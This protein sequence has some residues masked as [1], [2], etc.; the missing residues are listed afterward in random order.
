MVISL[1]IP[2]I[3]KM[4]K[5]DQFGRCENAFQLA[6]SVEFLKLGYDLIKSKPGNMVHGS[7]RQT[8]D[9]LPL[10]WFE[11]TSISLCKESYVF[12]PARRV[13]IPKPNGKKRPLG[14]SS[15]RDKII[16]QSLKILLEEVLETKFS[17]Y[18]HGFRPSRGCHSALAQIRKW[19][20]M[21]W[22]LEGCDK[23]DV[24]TPPFFYSPI[25]SI[26]IHMYI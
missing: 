5:Y 21:S 3:R 14:I 18:S 25:Y 19:K 4:L 7:D 8:L 20:G 1:R 10:K 22:V 9:G 12:K 15:P 2:K 26:H 11:E 17:K 23:P 13:Y 6:S 16:P 24:P